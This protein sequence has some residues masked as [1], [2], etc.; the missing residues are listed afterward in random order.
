MTL[1]SAFIVC[2]PHPDLT[3]PPHSISSSILQVQLLLLRSE[4]LP[5]GL[6]AGPTGLGPPSCRQRCKTAAESAS[7]QCAAE[8]SCSML[9][10]CE[11]SAGCI[12]ERLASL[13]ACSCTVK[14]AQ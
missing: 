10:M 8:V 14:H 5:T 1:V 13:P 4:E 3:A 6:A 12:A 9:G 2:L 7:R 11:G